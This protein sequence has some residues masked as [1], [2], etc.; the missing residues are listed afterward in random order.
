[1]KK[2]DEQRSIKI[3]ERKVDTALGTI[4]YEIQIDNDLFKYK[5]KE[6]I[7]EMIEKRLRYATIKYILNDKPSTE[8]AFKLMKR[9][10]RK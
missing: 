8:Q 1:M 10:K 2:V 6:E 7:A 9:R 3:I 5:S 4:T